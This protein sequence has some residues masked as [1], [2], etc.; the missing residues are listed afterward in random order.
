MRGL[1]AQNSPNRG[2]KTV[3]NF[4]AGV[5]SRVQYG[6]RLLGLG[7][8]LH[9]SDGLAYQ[10]CVRFLQTAFGIRLSPAT[11][12]RAEKTTLPVLTEQN[13]VHLTALRSEKVTC[14]DETG[15]MGRAKNAVGT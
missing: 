12:E 9:L 11:L 8:Y 1:L 10:R 14:D 2:Q 7:V 6:G 5:N 15:D 4:P 13:A 3:G